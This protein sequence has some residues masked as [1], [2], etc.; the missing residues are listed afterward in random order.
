MKTTNQRELF[1]L[2]KAI[3]M[4]DYPYTAL[5]AVQRN[6]AKEFVNITDAICSLPGDRVFLSHA[7][8]KITNYDFQDVKLLVDSATGRPDEFYCYF[9]TNPYYEDD[10]EGLSSFKDRQQRP[11]DV[12]GGKR[13]LERKAL[14]APLSPRGIYDIDLVEGRKDLRTFLEIKELGLIN[15]NDQRADS[16][17]KKP[18]DFY[19]FDE[20]LR[21]AKGYSFVDEM[22]LIFQH[23]EKWLEEYVGKVYIIEAKIEEISSQYNHF[24]LYILGN[25]DIDSVVNYKKDISPKLDISVASMVLNPRTYSARYWGGGSDYSKFRGAFYNK[26]DAVLYRTC[27]VLEHFEGINSLIEQNR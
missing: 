25:S 12:S 23:P 9:L 6:S 13:G 21:K 16:F 1:K 3:D 2:K 15:D 26:E 19:L 17:S 24:F 11:V 20:Y 22:T 18:F 5:R 14:M 4:V 10:I 27:E 8:G 7:G